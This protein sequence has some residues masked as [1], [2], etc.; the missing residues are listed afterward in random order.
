MFYYFGCKHFQLCQP[1]TQIIGIMSKTVYKEDLLYPELSYKIIGCA[2]EVFNEIGGGHRE[3]TYQKAL[4][5]S[6]RDAGLSFMEQKYFPVK[7][8]GTPVEKGFFYF[9]VDEKIIVEIKS[10]GY[11]TKDNY[12]QVLS[13]LNNSRQKIGRAHV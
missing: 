7:F 12:E 13:Y 4:S 2:F 1:C 11:F 10:L 9:F 3:R 6:F 8:M 5:L